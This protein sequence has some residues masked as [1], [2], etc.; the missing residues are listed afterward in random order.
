MA[1]IAI[2]LVLVALLIT[3]ER[4]RR[5]AA[6]DLAGREAAVHELDAQLA[7]AR[8]TAAAGDDAAR[9][10]GQDRDAARAALDGRTTERD[11]LRLE[12]QSVGARIDDAQQRV[13]FGAVTEQDQALELLGTSTC[14]SGVRI[15]RGFAAE[16]RFDESTAAMRDVQDVCRAASSLPRGGQGPAFPFD[17]ADPFVLRHGDTYYAYATN[18]AGGY[19]QTIRSTDLQHWTLVGSALLGL[20]PWA[21]SR[22]T[23]AP[24]VLERDGLFVLYYTARERASGQQCISTAWSLRPEGPFVDDTVAPTICQ[25]DRGGSIDPS[26]FVAADGGVH[27]VWKSED[28]TRGGR[29]RI[30]S[31]GLWG[32]W[33][34]PVGEPQELVHADRA[35][36]QGTVEGPSL[37][38]VEG[39]LVLLYSANRWFTNDY[40]IG[41]AVCD[42]PAGPCTKPTDNVVVAAHDLVGGPGGPD[43]VRSPDGT[44][45]LS[46][47]AWTWPE[48]G[49]PN[50]RQLHVVPLTARDGRPVAGPG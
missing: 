11:G 6:D 3:V 16:G 14:L 39:H 42:T 46:F 7:G 49:F 31:V 26:P 19:I 5:T 8:R 38:D 37:V 24:S 27:L 4:D 36:E 33:R 13:F 25:H 32:D 34:T 10:A 22:A 41:Y 45:N 40:W 47:H 9:R 2:E 50:K 21:A 1:V 17:F 28:D 20:P 30:W 48:I 35:D 15:A 18:G 12:L 43:V 44:P 29:S 23:W